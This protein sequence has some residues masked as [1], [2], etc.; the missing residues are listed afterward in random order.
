MMS[1]ILF[2]ASTASHIL[3]FH[4]P[5]LEKL[6]ALGYAVDVA[7]GGATEIPCTDRVISLP[8]QKRMTS[9]DNFRA[10]FLLHRLIQ[11]ERYGLIC[12]HTSL[13]AFFTRL[14]L[15]GIRR[16]PPLVNMVHGYLFDGQTPFLKRT[17]LL[18]AERWMAARTDLVLTMNQW[19]L[20]CAR[21]YRLGKRVL[22]IPGVGV[23]F[24]RLDQTAPGEA[25]ALRTRHAIPPDAFVVLYAAEFSKRKNQAVL[26]HALQKL[27][28]QVIL[29]LAGEGTLLPQCRALAERLGISGRVIFPGFVEKMGPWYQLADAVASS[30]RSE[31]LPFH[32]ME[33]M[34]M[35]LPVVAS[36]V[37]GHT[38]LIRSGETGLLYPWHD[39]A[40]CASA[41]QALLTDPD[42]KTRLGV[43]ARKAVEPYRLERVLPQVLACYPLP[44]VQG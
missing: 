39:A 32:I 7:C 43:E 28:K 31:G 26:L 35:G 12:T 40:A 20:E 21:Q 17:L 6:R 19:D 42:L 9:P 41:V 15:T 30:S 8:F 13:A 22:S 4:L 27:P 11:K 3:R 14:A 18:T 2:T 38:D 25:A 24:S 33:A 34:H 10:A 29:V 37:K 36:A 1:K 16:R 23:D 44:A 5:Y